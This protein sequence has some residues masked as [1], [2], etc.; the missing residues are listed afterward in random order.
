LAAGTLAGCSVLLDTS[1]QQCTTNVDCSSR[2]G[3]FASTVCSNH[4][5]VPAG[6]GNPDASAP[7]ADGGGEA[8]DDAP[9]DPVWGC[10][11]HVILETPAAPMV[12]VTIPFWDLIR[13]VP[14]NDVVARTCSKLDVSC[15]NPVSADVETDAQGVLTLNVPPRFDGYALVQTKTSGDGGSSPTRIPSLIFFNPPLVKDREFDRVPLFNPEDLVILAASQGNTIDPQL[16]TIFAGTQDCSGKAVGGVTWQPS[17]VAEST[18]RFFYVNGLP[19][20]AATATDSSGL[21]GLINV[22][23]GTIRLDANL[24]NTGMAIGSA[25][26][27]VRSAYASY[28][29][30]APVP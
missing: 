6:P 27:L 28:T 16:G 21:G 23:T 3:A 11:G 20:E 29:Y 9:S 10:L 14:I 7:A 1:G 13:M 24:Q 17:R 4:V 30:L 22:P 26:V 19:D 18:K 2:G 12:K 8:G 5:C 15:S 25:T